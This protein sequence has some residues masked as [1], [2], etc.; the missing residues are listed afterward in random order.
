MVAL[1]RLLPENTKIPFMRL[2]YVSFVIS[3]GLIAASIILFF[4]M[5]LNYGIDFRGGTMIEVQSSTPR[6]DIADVRRR[7]E[8][9]GLGDVQVQ[10]FGSPQDLMVRIG[11]TGEREAAAG[12]ERVRQALG[13]TYTIRRTES[14]GPAVSAELVQ[15]SIIALAL[16]VLAIFAYLWFRFEWQ[17]ALGAIV[18]TLHDIF[19]TVGL[20]VILRLDFDLTSI[21]AILTIMGYSLNDTVVIYDR[22]REMLRKYKQMPLEELIDASI[23]ATL[24][25]SIITS[26]TTFFASIALYI[27]GGEVLRGFSLAMLFGV[28]V[29]T[30]STIYVASPLLIHLHLRRGTGKPIVDAGKPAK[31]RP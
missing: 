4:V 16:G 2:R 18:T 22:I 7:V 28:I 3:G 31:A 6:A 8:G 27:F 26:A 20:F 29:G 30:F 23:N 5:G 11:A 24:S 13:D 25:R 21:A 15:Q 9:L 17:F 19:L 10:E 14:V 12:I 1:V